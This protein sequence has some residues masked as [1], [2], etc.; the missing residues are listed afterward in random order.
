MT[1]ETMRPDAVEP[2]WKWLYQVAGISGLVLGAGYLAIF[3][4][5]AR[6]GPPPSSAEAWLSYLAGKTTVWWVILWL[7]VLTTF[8]SCLSLLLSIWH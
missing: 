3:P 2:G 6:V 8:S 4:L 5:Y 1:A 7:S